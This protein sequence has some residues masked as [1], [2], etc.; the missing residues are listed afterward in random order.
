[1][2]EHR[3]I[4]MVVDGSGRCLGTGSK[5]VCEF[6]AQLVT[7]MPTHVEERRRST[8]RESLADVRSAIRI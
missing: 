3:D 2:N 4:Y 1:M 7:S 6:L 5:A 8:P